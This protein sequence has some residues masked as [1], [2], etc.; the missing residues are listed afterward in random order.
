VLLQVHA[1]VRGLRDERSSLLRHVLVRAPS[2]T[3][4][5]SATQLRR[6]GSYNAVNGVPSC[7]NDWLLKD[8]LRGN[9][10]F[11]GYVTSDCDA[12][13]DVFYSHNYTSTPEQAVADVLRC[14]CCRRSRPHFA[15]GR[16][17][18]S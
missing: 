1:A 12:D 2:R 9:W 3:Y 8:T 11:N 4:Y 10:Q 7:A 18:A 15:H 13:S 14:A 6:A 5:L 16:G 17:C